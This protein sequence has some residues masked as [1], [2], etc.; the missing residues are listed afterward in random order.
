MNDIA[1]HLKDLRREKKLSQEALAQALH[2]TR[3]T[4][5]AWER[6][7]ARPDVDTLLRL[8]QVLEVEPERLLYGVEP[9]QKAPRYRTVPLWPVLG[10]IPIFYL[11]VFWVFPLFF[12]WLFHPFND[13]SFFLLC[14][15]LFLAVVVVFCYCS[16]KDEI[17]NQRFYDR[18][19]RE[20]S[21][22]NAPQG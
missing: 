21:D 22:E 15:Q 4:V 1:A 19:E 5:S 16:L 17:R 8:A 14:G 18:Q 11:V 20:S 9:S 3:Q 6:G 7:V 13:F 2:V 10:V 12:Q